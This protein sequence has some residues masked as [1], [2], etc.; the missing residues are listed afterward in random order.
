[1]KALVFTAFCIGGRKLQVGE[2]TF[3]IMALGF[4]A[5]SRSDVREGSALTFGKLAP[6]KSFSRSWLR[7]NV[8]GR[9]V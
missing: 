6:R 4:V 5:L 3:T 2:D 7:L 8:L 9:G 1:M